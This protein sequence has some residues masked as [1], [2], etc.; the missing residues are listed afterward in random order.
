M[1][2]FHSLRPGICNPKPLRR[3]YTRNVAALCTVVFMSLALLF[4]GCKTDDDF[5]DDGKL[6]SNLIGTWLYTDEWGTDGYTIEANRVTYISDWFPITGTVKHVTNFT[7]SAGVIIIE[8]DTEYH[9]PAGNFI[10]IYFQN[11]NPKVSVQM[12]TAWVEGGA[13]ES[14]FDAAKAAFTA[15]NEGTYMSYYGT[16]S[17]AAD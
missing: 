5:I 16:Y 8:Y 17:W 11:L 7:D 3:L 9:N 13:E 10:G 2:L 1:F 14:T 12:G 6:N 4:T 15:G